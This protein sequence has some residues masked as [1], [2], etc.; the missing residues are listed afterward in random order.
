MFEIDVQ[1]GAAGLVVSHYSHMPRYG[2]LH[3]DGWRMRWGQATDP[4]AARVELV[5]PSARVLLDLKEPRA[6]AREEM[7]ATI[8]AFP[9]RA[10]F[11]ASGSHLDDFAKLRAVGVETWRS[12]GRAETLHQ[13]LDADDVGADGVTVRH[14]LLTA[15]IVERLHAKVPLVIAWTVNTRAR[16]KELRD[17]GVD[18]ITTDRPA[19]MR[20]LTSS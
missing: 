4:L 2:N 17:M 19:V 1:V 11:V 15:Q 6:A 3:R 7:I 18:G 14:T 20:F 5:P 10:R 9:N 16:A 13:V 8:C 12:V